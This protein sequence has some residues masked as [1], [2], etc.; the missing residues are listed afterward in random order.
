M[1]NKEDLKRVWVVWSNDCTSI[2]ATKKIA[3]KRAEVG[4]LI[5][6]A[7]RFGEMYKFSNFVWCKNSETDFEV[8]KK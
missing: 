3:F 4:S 7:T 1:K 2:Y 6:V 5:S 8:L